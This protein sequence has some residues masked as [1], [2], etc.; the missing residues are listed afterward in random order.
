[1]KEYD[2]I[3][4][5][6]GKKPE[7]FED[8]VLVLHGELDKDY[9]CALEEHPNVIVLTK[10]EYYKELY[11]EQ[12]F[13]IQQTR[14]IEFEQQIR[15]IR[16]LLTGEPSEENVSE[17]YSIANE[18]LKKSQ[19]NKQPAKNFTAT[20]YIKAFPNPARSE[21]TVIFNAL[22]NGQPYKL[23]VTDASGEAMFSNAGKTNSGR[24]MVKIDLR[25]YRTGI[26]HLT[27]ITNNEIKAIKI[28]KEK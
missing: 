4:I 19:T 10:K 20:A 23:L 24:N 11:F 9:T 17:A 13:A 1:M 14:L 3:F 15:N 25:K 27:L 22:Q 12:H 2:K 18:F 5:P 16:D 21:I 7:S 8:W 28:I 6:S 26:Y